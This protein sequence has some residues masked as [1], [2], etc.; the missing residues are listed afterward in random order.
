MNGTK[1]SKTQ[2]T[3][4]P[5][6]ELLAAANKNRVFWENRFSPCDGM[7]VIILLENG[8]ISIARWNGNKKKWFAHSNTPQDGSRIIAWRFSPHCIY[9]PP[10]PKEK[11]ERKEVV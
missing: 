11:K 2:K 10:K 9:V 6:K 4:K 7:P 8:F 1:Q 3:Q 5:N